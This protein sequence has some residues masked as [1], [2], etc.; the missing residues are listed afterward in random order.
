MSPSLNRDVLTV[1]RADDTKAAIHN[2]MLDGIKVG[3]MSFSV[4]TLEHSVETLPY[5]LHPLVE[6]KVLLD[7]DGTVSPLLDRI[8]ANFDAH[9]EVVAEWPAAYERLGAREGHLRLRED[10]HHRRMERA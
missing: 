9:P 4:A 7:R 5:L 2:R 10:D 6:A 8:A 1:L 3:D